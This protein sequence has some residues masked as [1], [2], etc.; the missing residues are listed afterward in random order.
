MN[1]HVDYFAFDGEPKIHSIYSHIVNVEHKV[2]SILK[3]EF[4]KS[5]IKFELTMLPIQ[6]IHLL[7]KC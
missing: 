2:N 6:R 1:A 3:T 4:M 7:L 5:V